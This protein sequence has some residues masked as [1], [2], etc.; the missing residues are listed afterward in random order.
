MLNI[1]E[2]RTESSQWNQIGK[3][4]PRRKALGERGLETIAPFLLLTFIFVLP[5]FSISLPLCILTFCLQT[6]RQGFKIV[7]KPRPKGDH[8]EGKDEK[9]GVRTS[10]S[11][12][13]WPTK[14]EGRLDVSPWSPSTTTLETNLFG[15]NVWAMACH[16]ERGIRGPKFGRLGLSIGQP[17]RNSNL[18]SKLFGLSFMWVELE[19]SLS[20]ESRPN[21]IFGPGLSFYDL[22]RHKPKARTKFCLCWFMCG[23]YVQGELLLYRKSKVYSNF[24]LAYNAVL[25][26][27]ISSIFLYFYFSI[28]K[29]KISGPSSK[30]MMGNHL[31]LEL[32]LQKEVVPLGWWD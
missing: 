18:L 4:Y 30:S 31:M 20:S 10:R 14:E 29:I 3:D 17:A 26:L 27:Y 12:P 8:K 25:F 22:T 6:I 9:G 21:K 11:L 32:R 5:F 15:G 16:G 19:L 7:E 1:M 2:A 13:W 24:Q 23:W 28:G